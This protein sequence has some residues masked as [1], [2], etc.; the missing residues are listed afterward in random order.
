M[1]T[2]FYK[3]RNLSDYTEYP[4][5]IYFFW[6]WQFELTFELCGEFDF[7]PRINIALIFFNLTLVL[8][9]FS[10]Y[11]NECIPPK[12][13]IA[14]HN[15]NFWIYRGGKG[16]E[17]GGNKWWTWELPFFAWVW[18]RSSILLNNDTWE[19]ETKRKK[20]NFYEDKWQAIR[21]SWN[22]DYT[23]SSDGQIIPTTI[24]VKE[25]EWRPKWLEWTKLFARVC[26]E[27]DIYFSLE[28][29]SEK[30]SYKGGVIRCSYKLLPNE[31]PL[32]CLKRMEKE[33][34]L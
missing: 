17:S 6:G 26:R 29:G 30:N 14:I 19:H 10:K 8:P 22:Y 2:W 21:K 4:Q 24:Y 15:N 11:E 23:D 33:R 25:S 9:F 27:I 20:N 3:L 34:K 28:C 13:G 7:R 16:N 32:D 5:W 12:W 18:V 1:K 31:H